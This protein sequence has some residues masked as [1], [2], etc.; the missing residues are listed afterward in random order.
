MTWP[1]KKDPALGK[2]RRHSEVL[3][4][5]KL[6]GVS[7]EPMCCEEKTKDTVVFHTRE[8]I[9]KDLLSEFLLKHGATIDEDE[10]CTEIS[11]HSKYAEDFEDFLEEHD[12]EV[13][14][15]N[16][17]DEIVDEVQSKRKDSAKAKDNA[18]TAKEVG[19]KDDAGDLVKWAK[20]PGKSDLRGVDTKE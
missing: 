2:A 12:I 18:Q 3:T 9:P 14:Q 11:M 10:K 7:N 17:A 4:K 6:K 8:R 20:D 13:E 19:E 1:E 5:K 16:I 15:D